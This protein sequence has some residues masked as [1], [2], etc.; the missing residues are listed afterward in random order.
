MPRTALQSSSP[1]SPASA[2][3]SVATGTALA[4][5]FAGGGGAG[6]VGA[7]AT[8]GA[9]PRCAAVP[10]RRRHHLGGLL[11]GREQGLIAAYS[12]LDGI[13]RQRHL[14]GVGPCT[15]E[16]RHGSMAGEA[17]MAPPAA[18]V[19][20]D[21]PPR[22]RQGGFRVWAARLGM[23]GAM[24]VSTV[25]QCA[26]HLHR[27]LE[28]KKAVPTVIAEVQSRPT[29]ST[30]VVFHFQNHTRALRVFRPAVTPRSPP[31]P[32]RTARCNCTLG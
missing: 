28:R 10:I 6:G 8:A 11:P 19:P 24:A 15:A 7:G 16:L 32:R 4:N 25:G 20:A 29:N 14:L 13:R 23:R 30:H 27:S 21:E 22:Q 17:A 12:I 5:G 26:H 18:H 9:R 2:G 1:T 3:G 31:W